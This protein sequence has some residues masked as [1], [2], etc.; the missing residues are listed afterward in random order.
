MKP[1]F[2]NPKNTLQLFEFKNDFNFFKDLLMKNEFPKVALLSGQ[3]F[4][5]INFSQ[6]FNAFFL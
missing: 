2:F 6:S 5:Q 3:R 1:T 4:R